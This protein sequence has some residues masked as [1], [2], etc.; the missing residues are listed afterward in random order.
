MPIAPNQ[1]HKYLSPETKSLLKKVKKSPRKR[2]P[3]CPPSKWVTGRDYR[4]PTP[5]E[6]MICPF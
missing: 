3:A 4:P 1:M 6:R 2:G 5:E